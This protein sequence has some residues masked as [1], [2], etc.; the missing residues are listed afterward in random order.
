M[1]LMFS[2][3]YS[4]ISSFHFADKLNFLIAKQLH[5][6]WKYTVMEYWIITLFL[7]FISLTLNSP[8]FIY[9]FIYT[10]LRAS[11]FLVVEYF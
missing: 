3:F 8:F 11:D 2:S 7:T 10:S 9:L 1:L 6:S 5:P 4:F